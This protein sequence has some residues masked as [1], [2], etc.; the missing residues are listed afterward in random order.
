MQ[1]NPR[2][3]Q[4]LL[5]SAGGRNL[6]ITWMMESM[7]ALSSAEIARRMGASSSATAG[8]AGVEGGAGGMESS[9]KGKGKGHLSAEEEVEIS[10]LIEYCVMLINQVSV[11]LFLWLHIFESAIVFYLFS[12][13]YPD[14][15]ELIFTMQAYWD[16]KSVSDLRFDKVKMDTLLEHTCK[17]FCFISALIILRIF[18]S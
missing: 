8:G 10:K 6:F 7:D 1:T 13:C 5:D 15:F 14:D 3:L 11:L 4:H 18:V 9:G 16:A 17:L 2:R 12:Y